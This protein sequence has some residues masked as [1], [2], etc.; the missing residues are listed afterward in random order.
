MRNI[1]Q[2]IKRFIHNMG[3][4]FR[5]SWRFAKMTYL[6][7]AVQT[8]IN[9]IQP[10]FILIVLKYIIDA[11]AS[12]DGKQVWSFLTL[13]AAGVLFF[14]LA[15]MFLN[16][17]GKLQTFQIEHNI[18]LFNKKLWLNMDY[19]NFES[20]A[21]RD[22]AN[23]CV[24]KINPKAF[25]DQMAAFITNIGQLIGYVYIVLSL[26]PLMVVFLLLVIALNSVVTRTLHRI[27]Y[28]YQPMITKL[29]RRI[30][31]LFQTMVDFDA[32]QEVLINGA[33]NWL[34]QKYNVE[35]DEYLCCFRVKQR[36]I[37]KLQVLTL[38]IDL[39]QSVVVY[40]YCGYFAIIGNIS[41]GSFTVFLGAITAFTASFVGVVQQFLDFTQ[42]SHYIDDY[43]KFEKL[44]EHA[45][46]D[47]E[48][49]RKSEPTNGKYDIEFV[50]VSFK[51]PNT[52]CYVLRNVNIV[53]RDGE[54]LSIVGYNGSGKTTFIKLLCRLYEP[55]EGKI[56]VGGVDI[57]TI[58]L[59]DYRKLLSVVFQDPERV[60]LT[61]RE[62]IVMNRANNEDKLQNAIEQS[63]LAEK[64]ASLENGVDTMLYRIYDY[65]AVIFSGGE[66]QK[67]VCAR[68]YYKDT[69]IVI[70]DEP[71][72]SLDP[73]AEARLYDRFQ[74]IIGPKT[75]LYI[76][77]RLAS[78]KFCDSI[79]VFVDGKIIERG[80]HD[81]LLNK[82]G[83]Y[84]E[85]YRK[86]AVYYHKTALQGKITYEQ[87]GNPT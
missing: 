31:Y 25:T 33:A 14:N 26:H 22:L 48:V 3:F 77:H 19:A 55:T 7:L 13:Y 64:I 54:R 29:S 2:A 61:I 41:I 86:Q 72:A 36:R 76:S 53:I 74:S 16:W 37:T 81:E 60:G 42:L 38:I 34:N 45:G 5:H 67:L 57:S 59:Q 10:F 50:N 82:G 32:S 17:L 18:E 30:S 12:G 43:R 23:R 35:T 75:A 87:Q 8:V 69:P 6:F 84:A 80:K 73:M 85:M 62:N 46:R 4:M 51:Y 47:R 52:D 40:G 24:N 68:A 20:G 70:L 58:N 56:Q 79:A 49:I 9:I 78:V 27:D 71:T 21:V 28:E 11:L 15:S 65:N 44:T 63:G 83:A 66:N 39:V 1:I